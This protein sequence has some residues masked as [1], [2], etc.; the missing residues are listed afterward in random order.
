VCEAIRWAGRTLAAGAAVT[1]TVTLQSTVAG[2][3]AD[4]TAAVVL[5]LTPQTATGGKL[6][7]LS[8]FLAVGAVDPILHWAGCSEWLPKAVAAYFIILGACVVTAIVFHFGIE[9]PILRFLH[10]RIKGRRFTPLLP[11]VWGL[12]I[13]AEAGK[14]VPREFSGD[15][16]T[17]MASRPLG[18]PWAKPAGKA[19]EAEAQLEP[20]H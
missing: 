17:T 18:K 3:I 8:F 14:L 7:A 13:A 15:E 12:W 5:P 4:G 16:D 20:A 1:L 11:N 6:V 10:Q 9:Q 19:L 2:G